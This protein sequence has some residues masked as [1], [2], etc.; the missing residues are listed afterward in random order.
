VADLG[1]IL[2]RGLGDFGA[3]RT[4]VI[5]L[6]V[7]YPIVGLILARLAF[8][9]DMLPLLFP[10]ASGFALV[11]PFAAVGLYE[12]SRQREQGRKVT[13]AF[14]LT[15]LSQAPAALIRWLRRFG[16]GASMRR[17]ISGDAYQARARSRSG[18]SMTIRSPDQLPSSS[19]T[20]PPCTRYRPPNGTSVASILWRYSWMVG[21]MAT[22]RSWAMA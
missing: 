13:W 6:C 22:L 11:G 1:D 21:P 20:S 12:M 3:Y 19:S 15:S 8:G 17:A 4:D 14:D 7:V 2:A 18:N 9:Y 10:L 5:Y 16:R